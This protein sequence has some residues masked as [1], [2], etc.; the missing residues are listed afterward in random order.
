[1]QVDVHF[2]GGIIQHHDTLPVF[3]S[4]EA[5]F[6]NDEHGIAPTEKIVCLKNKKINADDY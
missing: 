3:E 2:T 1:M 6:S 4:L 5:C